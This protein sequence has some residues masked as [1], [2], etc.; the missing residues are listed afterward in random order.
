MY[1][2]SEYRAITAL[3][4]KLLTFI[5]LGIFFAILRQSMQELWQRKAVTGV[6]VLYFVVFAGL[7]EG[8]QLALASKS[9]DMTDWLLQIIGAVIGLKDMR[10]SFPA[11][12]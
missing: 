8:M 5:P 12:I 3:M 10:S 1:F 2:G 7:V 4:Q 11:L 9:V 6:A